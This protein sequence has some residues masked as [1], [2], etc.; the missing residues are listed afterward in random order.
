MVRYLLSTCGS[1]IRLKDAVPTQGFKKFADV[2][3]H[4]IDICAVVG[5][6]L[7]SDLLLVTSGCNEFENLRSDGIEAEHLAPLDIKQDRAILRLGSSERAGDR[8]HRFNRPSLGMSGGAVGIREV[9]TD[10]GKIASVA[11]IATI[12]A[13][14]TTATDA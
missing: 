10:A 1:L 7:P 2:R 13:V 14:F 4:D 3:T 9:A 8:D 6:D 12:R 5:A 11:A